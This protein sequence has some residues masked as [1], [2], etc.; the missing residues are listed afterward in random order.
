MALRHTRAEA[1]RA[2]QQRAPFRQASESGGDRDLCWLAGPRAGP[3]SAP[4][5]GSDPFRGPV[6]LR[7]PV[8][9]HSAG[10][11]LSGSAGRFCY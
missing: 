4:F 1:G 2:E 6:L 3:G 5:H 10:R 11:F 8:P 7:R 9:V